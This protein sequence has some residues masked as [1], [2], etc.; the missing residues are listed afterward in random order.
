MVAL[1]EEPTQSLS[2]CPSL[3]VMQLRTTENAL[4]LRINISKG[5][6]WGWGG[7]IAKRWCYY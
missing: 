7:V 2:V 4:A 3:D 1:T 6:G 5:W